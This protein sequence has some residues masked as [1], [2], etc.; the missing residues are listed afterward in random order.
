MFTAIKN[1]IKRKLAEFLYG[2]IDRLI[3]S[4]IQKDFFKII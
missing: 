4:D 2:E 1:F 3:A